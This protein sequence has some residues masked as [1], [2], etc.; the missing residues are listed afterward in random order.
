MKLHAKQTAAALM[1]AAMAGTLLAGC[2]GAASSSTAASSADTTTSEASSTAEA[3]TADTTAADATTGSTPRNE[4]LYFGGQQWGVIND[5][6]PLSSN[7]NNALVINQVDSTRALFYESLFLYNQSDGK[8]YPCLGTDYKWND[9]QTEVTVTLNPD[10][11]WSDGTAFTADDVV[12]TFDTHVKYQSPTGADYSNYIDSVEKTDDHTVVFKAKL[13]DSGKAV[14]PLKVLEY[15]P[16]VYVMQKA[17]LQTVEARD[18]N[19]ADKIKTDTMEDAVHTGAYSNFYH[20]DQKVVFVRNDDYWG[21]A[22]SMWGKLPAPKYIAHTIYKDNAATQTAFAQGEIDVNQQFITDVQ[23]LWEE[24]N[25][26]ITTYIDKAPYGECA[27]LPSVFFNCTKPG[28]DQAAVRKAIAIAVDYDQIISSAM[29]NQSPTFAEVQRSIMNPT[30]AQQNMYDKDACKDLAWTG[31]DI[32]GAKK[33]LDDAGIKDTN[34]DGIREYNGT[35]LSFKVECPSGWSDWNA[36]LEIVA[37]AGKEI[38]IDLQTYF[39]EATV[40]TTD[41]STCNFDLIMYSIGGASV[42][43]PWWGAMQA[44]SSKYNDLATNTLCN[45][46]HYENADADKIL[47]AIPYETDEAKLKEDYTELNKIYLTDVPCF[48]LMY[49]PSLF[50]AVNESVWTGYPMKDDGSNIPPTDCTDGYGI[51][52]LYNLT[53]VNG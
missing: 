7:S 32:D 33:M 47:D 39:P 12:Y 20:D 53:L 24:Q 50:Y 21:Q 5:W 2:G 8:M 42:S 40:W 36:A 14:N 37:A 1:A 51:A 6:N 43:Q 16:K 19:D 38:G 9:A 17:Y 23:K 31:K 18:N 35:E 29:S 25:L 4:T 28:L 30:D 10:A 52:G 11:K 44:L 22:S 46:G 48:S 49:R 34:G 15:L 41:Y 45:F 27:V 26:P 13:D 3:A